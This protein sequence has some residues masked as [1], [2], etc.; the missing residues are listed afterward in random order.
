MARNCTLYD[1]NRYLA[2][3]VITN[4][5]W[6]S[7][8]YGYHTKNGV[9][10]DAGFGRADLCG[11]A[12]AQETRIELKPGLPALTYLPLACQTDIPH[13]FSATV[14]RDETYFSRQWKNKR[15]R[16][17][18]GAT[19]PGRGTFQSQVCD[20]FCPGGQV[21]AQVVPDVEA[22]TLLPRICRRLEVGSSVCSDPG[23]SDTGGIAAKG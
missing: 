11:F 22:K 3:F 16:L 17:K 6:A 23:T 19:K 1:E 8:L 14:E 7:F 10:F 4:G 15:H 21:W 18:A 13:L 20:I 2:V 12:M 5:C 9:R